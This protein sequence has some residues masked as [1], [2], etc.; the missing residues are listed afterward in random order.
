ML[1]KG[2]KK[3]QQ[4]AVLLFRL[5]PAYDCSINMALQFTGGRAR[6]PSR[7]LNSFVFAFRVCCSYT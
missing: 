3:A 6:S 4:Q 5:C 1:K 2:L 7:V